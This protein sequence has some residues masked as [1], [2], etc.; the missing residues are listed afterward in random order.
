M[1][2]DIRTL[3]F[4]NLVVAF[5]LGLGMIAYARSYPSAKGFLTIS[6]GFLFIAGSMSLV[7]L[8]HY[9]LIPTAIVTANLFSVAGLFFIGLGLLKHFS[10]NLKLFVLLNIGLLVFTLV[11]MYFFTFIHNQASYRI[12]SISTALML[13]SMCIALYLFAVVRKSKTAKQK[14]RFV[15]PMFAVFLLSFLLFALRIFWTSQM[16]LSE[17][18][19]SSGLFHGFTAQLFLLILLVTSF[20]V[21]WSA[22]QRLEMKLI[23]QA[24]IDPL[25]KV[26]NRRAMEEFATKI[27]A[28][29][30]RYN[31]TL[32]VI[33]T[34]I[35]HFKSVNDRY[36]HPAGDAL[37]QR[38]AEILK[39]NI[40]GEDILARYGG[41]EF[42]FLLPNCDLNSATFLAEKLRV[43]V[44]ESQTLLGNG[45]SL[46]IT[47]SFGITSAQGE[48]I[49]W[50][51]IV[52]HAD[53]ALYQ[54][55][56]Q[57]RNR[58]VCYPMN[59]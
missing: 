57:G 53:D 3:V 26:Y 36:G 33:I 45:L 41:E 58:V 14:E 29:A 48:N 21:S 28:N 42:L 18:S 19:L 22:N 4:S 46:S 32:S 8:P 23:E 10:L 56:K 30:K 31:Q 5:L 1:D 37:L 17:S 7:V 9:T 25:T 20:S 52:S 44:E 12:I 50:S 2:L 16:S 43:K 11:T 15:T 54:A 49:I 13:Q 55:K 24:T 59:S 35:D 6:A 51:Q 27:L 40:R 34:D 38:F 39:S 47:A